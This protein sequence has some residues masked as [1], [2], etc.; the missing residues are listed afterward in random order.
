LS[1]IREPA[2]DSLHAPG[3]FFLVLLKEVL[4]LARPNN[5]IV[6][7][8]FVLDGNHHLE[9]ICIGSVRDDYA[10]WKHFTDAFG[11]SAQL[12][13]AAIAVA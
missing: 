13:Q 10:V 4:L 6:A 11:G 5:L 8:S 7:I 9:R 2:L 12:L 3:S 1:Q